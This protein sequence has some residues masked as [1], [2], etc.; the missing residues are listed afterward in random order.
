[1]TV[2]DIRWRV[3]FGLTALFRA[4]P[5]EILDVLKAQWALLVALAALRLQVTGRLLRP[6]RGEA[7]TGEVDEE[8]VRRIAVA[9]DRAARRGLFR[10]TC[11]VRSIALERLVER[12]GAGNAVVR[13]GVRREEGA[14]HAHAW[15]EVDGQV[16]GDRPEHV[17][18]FKPI[19]DASALRR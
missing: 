3:P 9:V 12:A 7:G 18:R 16:V 5:R 6:V 14:L 17:R 8:Y 11:L 2:S 15:I 4:S 13:V 19:T 1:M 10:P